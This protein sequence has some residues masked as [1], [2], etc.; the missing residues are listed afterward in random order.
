MALFAK[1]T[2]E[3]PDLCKLISR[4]WQTAKDNELSDPENA[5]LLKVVTSYYKDKLDERIKYLEKLDKSK[6][7][8]LND[9]CKVININNGSITPEKNA[10]IALYKQ[11]IIDATIYI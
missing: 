9:A 4:P 3:F 5:G 2:Q 10:A 11:F 6:V 7:I 8:I 1:L